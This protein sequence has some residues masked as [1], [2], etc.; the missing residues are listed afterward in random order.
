MITIWLT[1]EQINEEMEHGLVNPMNSETFQ[2]VQNYG[3]H[4]ILSLS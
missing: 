1:V 2:G 3:V 4:L